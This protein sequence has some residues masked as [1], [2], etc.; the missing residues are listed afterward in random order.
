[1]TIALMC[2]SAR[3]RIDGAAGFLS[4]GALKNPTGSRV[5]PRAT[6][7]PWFAAVPRKPRAVQPPAGRIVPLN[8]RFWFAR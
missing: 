7:A 8:N 3:P 5:R 6:E 2:V 4:G 1:M